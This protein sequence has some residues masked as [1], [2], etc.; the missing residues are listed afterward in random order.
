MITR[1]V[2]EKRTI[3]QAAR[4]DLINASI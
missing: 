4:T 3:E 2:K 1:M